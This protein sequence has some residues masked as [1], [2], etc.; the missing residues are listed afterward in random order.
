VSLAILGINVSFVTTLPEND[1]AVAAINSLRY[2]GIDT[3]KILHGAGRMGLYYL[4]CGY[5][6]RSSKVI[7]DRQYSAFALASNSKY[8][9]D[10]IFDDVTWFHWSG[11]TPAL[12]DNSAAACRD[13]C[14]AAK[15]KGIKV[16]CDLNYR[17]SLWTPDNAQSVMSKL[18]PYV[19]LCIAN[20]EDIE[21]MLG[22][23]NE[24]ADVSKGKLTKSGYAELAKKAALQYGFSH[25][26]ITLRE[27]YSA[28]INGWSALLYDAHKD[29]HYY[30]KRYDIDVVDRVGG[31]D[32]FSAGLI[33]ELVNG[34]T[35]Q[36]A[37]DFAVAASCLKHSIEGDFNRITLHEIEQLTK[38]GGNGRIDR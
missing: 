28:N 16:S 2:F 11:I 27:S 18:M 30:S 38:T 3:S 31:G 4:E 12:S 17:K 19:E 9:W 21:K 36:E 14:I 7:Y 33:Y 1:I 5:S 37:V 26:A 15:E 29:V 25:V 22:I 24:Q 32:S 13:A 34:K 23:R 8:D 20:E 10:A 35:G 6:Q